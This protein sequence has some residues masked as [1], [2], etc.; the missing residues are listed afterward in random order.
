MYIVLYVNIN[1]NF[2]RFIE[3]ISVIPW[4]SE[5]NFD[6]VSNFIKIFNFVKYFF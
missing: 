1:I 6:K 2:E 4:Y 3:T 5:L